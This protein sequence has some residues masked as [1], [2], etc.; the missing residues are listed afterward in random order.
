MHSPWKARPKTSDRFPGWDSKVKNKAGLCL[1]KSRCGPP[2]P[3]STCA[4]SIFREM[5]TLT[6][7]TL[8]AS[9]IWIW[10][11]RS[12]SEALVPSLLTLETHPEGVFGGD[13]RP[14]DKGTPRSTVCL[15]EA[16][17][18]L[19]SVCVCLSCLLRSVS[20]HVFSRWKQKRTS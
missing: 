15:V 1:Y 20:G 2:C 4:L 14:V 19:F 7:N 3:R 17:K 5:C 11:Q 13:G 10:S 12:D 18:R 6:E 8:L 16:E 9:L